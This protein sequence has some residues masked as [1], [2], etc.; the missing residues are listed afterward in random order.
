MIGLAVDG[1]ARLGVV[2]APAWNRVLWAVVGQGAWERGVDGVER[3]LTVAE[4]PGEARHARMVVS[5]SHL[6]PRVSA[7]SEA[8]GIADVHPCG[9]VGLK[10]ALVASGEADLYVHAGPGP[11]LWDGCAPAAIALAAGARVTDGAGREVRF[12]AGDLRLD[13]GL[14]VAHPALHALALAAFPR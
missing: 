8:L 1:R 11:K 5:R 4:P 6:H 2:V 7:V 3:P 9:S 10:V 12:D 14:V 13:D